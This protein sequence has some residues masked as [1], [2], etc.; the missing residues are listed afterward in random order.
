MLKSTRIDLPW[1]NQS[2][3]VC[4]WISQCSGEAQIGGSWLNPITIELRMR[5]I[6]QCSTRL[7]QHDPGRRGAGRPT[8][9]PPCYHTIKGGVGQT[10]TPWWH[11]GSFAPWLH[12]SSSPPPPSPAPP[13]APVITAVCGR[14]GCVLPVGT[15][16]SSR[17]GIEWEVVVVVRQCSAQVKRWE[18]ETTGGRGINLQE[19]GKSSGGR[20]RR[21]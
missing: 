4:S 11:L 17:S 21:L 14:G 1:Q 12:P 20:S 13:L 9:R 5:T 15:A 7:N 18:L 2:S 6:G 16:R 3:Y 8:P 10:R 19:V